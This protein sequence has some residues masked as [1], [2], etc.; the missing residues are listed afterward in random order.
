M[1]NNRDPNEFQKAAKELIP[2]LK[3]N[4]KQH[5]DDIMQNAEMVRDAIRFL[6]RQELECEQEKATTISAE[7]NKND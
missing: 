2:R 1:Q 6:K 4:I 3:N 7:G 5:C